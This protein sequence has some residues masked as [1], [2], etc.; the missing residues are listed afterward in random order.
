MQVADSMQCG[1]QCTSSNHRVLLRAQGLHLEICHISHI[2]LVL[3]GDWEKD[4]RKLT[5]TAVPSTMAS[6]I[7]PDHRAMV[8]DVSGALLSSMQAMQHWRSI[9]LLPHHM[10]HHPP[11]CLT[12]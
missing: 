5:I 7:A 1:H 4:S 10:L 2:Q 6:E 9:D 3:P 8:V 12:S 11:V